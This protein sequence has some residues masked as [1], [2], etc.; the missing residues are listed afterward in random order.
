MNAT[1]EKLVNVIQGDYVI[2]D[3]PGVILTTVLGS[4]IAVCLYDLEAK[5]GGMNHFLLPEG[6]GSDAGNVRYGAN[7]MELLI[8]GLLKKGA[9]R[10]RLEAKIFGGAK[11]MG[12]LR[13]IGESNAKF[14]HRF[15]KDED[16][17]CLAEST[18]GTSARRIRFWPTTGLVRQLTVQGQ[19]EQ[20]APVKPAERP[21]K[22][23]DDIV[24]F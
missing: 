5:A 9:R 8:N 10:N 21:Q 6:D 18:G 19:I 13:N 4:C 1:Q 3:D 11:M 23:Q 24:L 14:A 20:V 17:P 22:K 2:S 16:I 12:N 15:L 7:A